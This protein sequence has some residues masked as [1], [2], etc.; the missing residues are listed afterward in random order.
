MEDRNLGDR[1]HRVEILQR[2]RVQI[3]GVIHV[4]SFD[5]HQVILETDKG[6]LSLTGEDFHITTLDL[7]RS[8]MTIEGNVLGLEYSSDRSR[9]KAKERGFLQR[10]FR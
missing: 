9:S 7:E 2:E 3:Q 6:M 4:E 1:V 5:E 8:E 10:I